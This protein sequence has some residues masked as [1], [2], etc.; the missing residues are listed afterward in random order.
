MTE[1]RAEHIKVLLDKTQPSAASLKW[2]RSRRRG[3]TLL[4]ELEKS[5]PA[6]VPAAQ[7]RLR[8]PGKEG[9]MSRAMAELPG[10]FEASAW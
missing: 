4:A 9:P 5:L 10:Q 3:R 6:D 7:A 1:Q 8:R 2:P